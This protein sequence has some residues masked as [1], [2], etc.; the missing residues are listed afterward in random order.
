MAFLWVEN[1]YVNT[2]Y[3][4]EGCEASM[5]ITFGLKGIQVF[6]PI[7]LLDHSKQIQSQK[8]NYLGDK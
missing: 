7:K 4:K 5:H 2:V 3:G 8:K 6:K 1:T